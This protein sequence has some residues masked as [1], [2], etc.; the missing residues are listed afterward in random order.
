MPCNTIDS[1]KKILVHQKGVDWLVCEDGSVLR[2][3]WTSFTTRNKNGQVQRFVSEHKEKVLAPFLSKSGYLVVSAKIGNKRPKM[4]LH[5]LIGIAFV[6]GYKEDLHINHINGN[7]TDNRPENLEWVT[8]EENVSH[9]WKTGLVDLRGEK[10][11]SHKLSQKQ[12]LH[13]RKAL[14]AGVPA[15]SLSIIANVNPSTIYLIEQGK[16]WAHLL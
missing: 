15:N 4:F 1:M 11:P 5:R 9:A 13:I 3:A 12:V 2:P 10:Q 16:R 14:R 8:N 7:K 6:P